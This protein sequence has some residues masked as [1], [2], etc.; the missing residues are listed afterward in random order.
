[1]GG[2]ALGARIIAGAGFA[3]ICVCLSGGLLVIFAGCGL[4]CVLVTLV[5][6]ILAGGGTGAGLGRGAVD[7]FLP[8]FTFR[9]TFWIGLIV[10]GLITGFGRLDGGTC[11]SGLPIG[12]DFSCFG[13]GRS[14]AIRSN[15]EMQCLQNVARILGLVFMGNSP[16]EYSISAA[17]LW[18]NATS[19]L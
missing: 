18:F 1:M 15:K 3:G 9:W 12:F 6:V 16:F 10:T 11:T 17:S 4:V 2:E 5:G 7:C 8:G 13:F 19:H 14:G